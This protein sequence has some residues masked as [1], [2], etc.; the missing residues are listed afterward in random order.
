MHGSKSEKA[1]AL[2]KCIMQRAETI[3]SHVL[4]INTT[5]FWMNRI[6]TT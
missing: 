2:W 4:G 3:A 1:I 5:F 6:N